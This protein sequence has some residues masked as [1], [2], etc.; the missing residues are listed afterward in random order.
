MDGILNELKFLFYGKAMEIGF[1]FREVV[2]EYI[3]KQIVLEFQYWSE[4]AVL[5]RLVAGGRI[6]NIADSASADF[7]N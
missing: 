7:L 5:E 2:S 3:D 4:N 1:V 6:G